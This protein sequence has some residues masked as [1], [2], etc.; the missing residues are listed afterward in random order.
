MSTKPTRTFVVVTGPVAIPG[1]EEKYEL[2]MPPLEHTIRG[3]EVKGYMVA[4]QGFFTI[5]DGNGTVV[6]SAP[7][8]H[9]LYCK[10]ENADGA[11]VSLDTAD[12]VA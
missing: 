8:H 7:T 11:L 5:V 10:V 6:F 3:K 1:G 12:E 9:V 2:V 4:D